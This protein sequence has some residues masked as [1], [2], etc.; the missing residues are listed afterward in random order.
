[1]PLEQQQQLIQCFTPNLFWDVDPSEIDLDKY[2]GHVIQR[3]LEYGQLSDWR[4]I[5]SFYGM[6]KIVEC[7]QKLRT[8][9][10]RALSFISCI[11]HTPKESFRC[12]TFA[13]SFPTLWNS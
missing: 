1:M 12:Y 9:D 8:L 11:S 2:P 4:L 13:Q 3:V 6:D 7:C 5:K 10:A